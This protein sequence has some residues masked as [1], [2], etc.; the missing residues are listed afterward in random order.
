[1]RKA[2]TKEMAIRY[3]KDSKSGKGRMLD[4]LCGL[5]VMIWSSKASGSG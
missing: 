5:D 3:A 1:M 4:E 2:V